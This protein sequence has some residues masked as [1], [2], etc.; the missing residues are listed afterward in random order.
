MWALRRRPD[1]TI[2]RWDGRTYRRALPLETG[3]VELA[4]VQAGSAAVPELT[5]T[6]TGA[7]LDE[8]TEEAARAAL[9]RL[10]GLELDLSKF[11]SPRRGRPLPAH[12]RRTLPRAEAAAVSDPLRV[13]RERNRLPATHAHSRHPSA[14]PTRRSSRDSTSREQYTCLSSTNSARRSLTRRAEATWL[15]RRQ[16]TQHYRARRQSRQRHVRRGRDRDARRRRTRSPPFCD[17]AEWGAGRPSMRFCADWD[18][19][20]CF[21]GT[22]SAPATTSR[23][24]STAA[25]PSTTLA[26]RPPYAGGSRSPGSSTFTS[27]SPTSPTTGILAESS[28]TRSSDGVDGLRRVSGR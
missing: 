20:T 13:P 12:T 6:L 24:G 8:Q 4:A 21:P 27:C 1:N 14:Q 11:S 23:A 3:G 19:C 10:L 18:G 2:D 22:T 28:L 26:F 16:V 9:A 7:Q 25:S 15:Q 5:V 17:C